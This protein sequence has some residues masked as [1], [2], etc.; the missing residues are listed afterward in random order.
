MYRFLRGTAHSGHHLSIS[1]RARPG[2]TH[3]QWSRNPAYRILMP[4]AHRAPNTGARWFLEAS[5]IEAPWYACWD[6][7]LHRNDD[8]AVAV[9]SCRVSWILCCHVGCTHDYPMAGR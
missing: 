7:L 4:N 2:A 6:F 8:I 3:R 5:H 9:F 1:T